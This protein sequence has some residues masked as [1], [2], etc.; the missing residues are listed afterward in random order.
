MKV[1]KE[2]AYESPVMAH[3]KGMKKFIFA[4]R[5]RRMNHFEILATTPTEAITKLVTAHGRQPYR[6]VNITSPS[7]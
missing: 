6:I 3:N 5:T 1:T 2:T 4:D 7:L